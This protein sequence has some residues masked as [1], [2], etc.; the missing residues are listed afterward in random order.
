MNLP[1]V[2][3]KAICLYDAEAEGTSLGRFFLKIKKMLDKSKKS[4]II[5]DKFI[6]LN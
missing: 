1:D 4:V 3:R 2:R 6:L 5:F